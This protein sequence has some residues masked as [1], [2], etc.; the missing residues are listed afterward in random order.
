MNRTIKRKR[1]HHYFCSSKLP[2]AVPNYIG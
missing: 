2:M 1:Y